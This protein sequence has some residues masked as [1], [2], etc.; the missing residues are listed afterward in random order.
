MI[1]IYFVFVIAFVASNLLV[2]YF[3]ATELLISKKTKSYEY[4]C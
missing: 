3:E 4:E 2:K 1:L